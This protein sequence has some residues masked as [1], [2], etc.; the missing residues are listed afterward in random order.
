MNRT[1]LHDVTT[2]GAV[3]LTPQ[4]VERLLSD[5]SPESRSDLLSRIAAN[6]NHELFY[7]RERE[8]AEHIFRLMMKDAVVRVR[9]TLAENIKDNPDVPRD[10]VLHVAQDVESVALPVLLRSKVLSDSD[11][12]RIVEQSHDIGKLLAI[13]RRETV[14]ER[15]STALVETR[16]PQVMT[17]LLKNDGASISDR[18]LEKIADDF[19]ADQKMMELLAK[20]DRL[21]I[22]VIER[23]VNQ[24]SEEVA[25]QLRAKYSIAGKQVDAST[26]TMREDFTL[27]LLEDHYT[28]DEETEALVLQMAQ[29]GRL[30]PSIAM[31]ALCRGQLKFFTMAMAK[32]AGIPH[33]NA[34]RLLADKGENGFY[35]IYQKSGLPE[36]MTQAVRLLLRAAQDMQEDS[37]IPG[38]MLYANRLAERV[39]RSAGDEPV[40][41]LPYFIALIRQNARR[42]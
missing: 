28:N 9:E 7:S 3:L 11:L 4:D 38:S 23:I 42:F 14:S 10:I 40:E 8:I 39:I 19:S 21:P 32:F 34:E 1:S 22:T 2:E 13:S 12:V 26:G 20:K 6:Y 29:E 33:T 36:S 5:D 15:V 17:S 24:V 18:S 27:R 30:T 41:Y 16:Y 35:G 31:T 25:N 37:A